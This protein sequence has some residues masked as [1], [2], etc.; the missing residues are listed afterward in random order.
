MRIAVSYD[1]ETNQVF[2][3]FGHA[4]AFKVYE[5]EGD[6]VVSSKVIPSNGMGHTVMV[7]LIK[8]EN[9]QVVLCGRIGGHAL[10]GLQEAGIV[11]YICD[12]EDADEALQMYLTGKA[13]E[14]E[15]TPCGHDHEE[16]HECCGGCHNEPQLLFE[17][18]NA[19]KAM[20]VHYRG[21]FN[22]GTQFDSSYDRGEPL[23]FT[24]AIGQM[25]R[26]F[27]EAVVNMEVGEE[28]DIHLMPEE[29]YGQRNPNA[30]FT[31]E[32]A[33]LPGSEELEVGQRVF[34]QNQFG[35]PFPVTVSAKDETTITFDANHEMAGKELNF[36]IEVV[37]I[38]E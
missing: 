20:R 16:Q 2:G 4:P 23:A 12:S 13:Q 28:T 6:N 3:H 32:I 27:D 14:A 25:I 37:S 5:V 7:N 10:D 17:G 29:A 38:D 8:Q 1:N 36:H 34:L 33:Q 24:C 9:I 22:D 30:V 11:A 15:A 35:Q 26:G 19:G 18:K 21:T 31:V